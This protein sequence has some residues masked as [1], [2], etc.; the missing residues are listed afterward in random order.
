MEKEEI[1]LLGLLGL[2]FFALLA[3]LSLSK[4]SSLPIT[5]VT[6]L[7]RDAYGRLIGVVS[8]R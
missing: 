7:E 8:K 2:S 4:P 5:E 3:F 1:V 6:Q